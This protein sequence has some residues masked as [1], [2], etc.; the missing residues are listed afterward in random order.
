MSRNYNFGN[1]YSNSKQTS[2]Q[3]DVSRFDTAITLQISFRRFI[4]QKTYLF[5][6]LQKEECRAV[7]G[8]WPEDIASLSEVS[9][10][11]SQL[12]FEFCLICRQG[13]TFRFAASLFGIQK[14]KL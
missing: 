2:N 9:S 1:E 13:L 10:L 12:L 14:G 11:P 7:C 3:H 4:Y 8:L 6:E 5:L